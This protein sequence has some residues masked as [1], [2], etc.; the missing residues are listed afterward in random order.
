MTTAM[1]SPLDHSTQE[2]RVLTLETTTDKQQ[3][4]RCKLSPQSLDC[5]K[6][7]FVAFS[8]VWG[9]NRGRKMIYVNELPIQITRN[10]YKLLRAVQNPATAPL[11]LRYLWIDAICINQE[12]GAERAIQV[13]LMRRIYREARFVVAWLGR[14]SDDSRLAFKV[15]EIAADERAAGTRLESTS[16]LYKN[17][18]LLCNFE[19]TPMSVSSDSPS[20]QS[21]GTSNAKPPY[22]SAWRSIFN[23]MRRP[24]FKRL[25]TFQ[26][27]VLPCTL[28]LLCGSE[29]SPLDN[30]LWLLNWVMNC[31]LYSCPPFMDTN[32]WSILTDKRY[33]TLYI[34]FKP[35]DRI[36]KARKH[37]HGSRNIQVSYLTGGKLLYHSHLIEHCLLQVSR[38]KPTPQ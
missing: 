18:D 24:Y 14:P 23:L 20:Q 11:Q 22:N 9:A 5:S 30:L 6:S 32:V 8:Y 26:E 17:K 3:P 28:F 7:S 35:L 16:W 13:Q 1:Y 33:V 21:N 2:I 19:E 36:Y 37:C 25:W 29:V 31:D 10:L 27:A 34:G 4:I 15:L 12:D 38:I